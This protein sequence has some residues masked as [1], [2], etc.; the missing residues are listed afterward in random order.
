MNS[1]HYLIDT[2]AQLF[3]VAP[4]WTN[5]TATGDAPDARLDALNGLKDSLNKRTK[6]AELWQTQVFQK[7]RTMRL[8]KY[9][10]LW[11]PFSFKGAFEGELDRIL[12]SHHYD[13]IWSRVTYFDYGLGCIE[14]SVGLQ[15]LSEEA[16]LAMRPALSDVK[17]LL[18]DQFVAGLPDAKLDITSIDQTIS[19]YLAQNEHGVANRLRPTYDSRIVPAAASLMCGPVSRNLLLTDSLGAAPRFECSAEAVSELANSFLN[20]TNQDHGKTGSERIPI[21]HEGFEGAVALVRRDEDHV[22]RIKEEHAAGKR[23]SEKCAAECG[24]V[25]R[26]KQLWSAVH[27]YWSS[28]FAASEGFFAITA[29]YAEVEADS[30]AQVQEEYERIDRYQKIISMLKFESQPEKITVEGEDRIRYNAIWRAYDAE[31]LMRALSQIQHDAE[32]TLEAL[33]DYA[34]KIMQQR[35]NRIIGAFTLLTLLSVIVD[36]ILLYDVDQSLSASFR[37]SLLAFGSLLLVLVGGTAYG[38]LVLLGQM[39]RGGRGR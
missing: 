22:D 23:F 24:E 1:E 31:E 28:M 34:Q 11:R 38:L 7:P 14:V 17:L 25:L 36:V 8:R 37:F 13:G 18:V 3:F 2:N 12:T 30:L 5:T 27:M 15:N 20:Q 9:G 21:S 29:S 4:Y 16:L 39:F 19:N 35:M 6:G 26:T 10:Q 32:T 33:R